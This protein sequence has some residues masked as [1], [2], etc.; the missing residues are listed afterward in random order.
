MLSLPNSLGS[1]PPSLAIL[2]EPISVARTDSSMVFISCQAHPTFMP[3]LGINLQIRP[4]VMF[5][6]NS[7]NQAL[8][9]QPLGD[10]FMAG[11]ENSICGVSVSTGR[12]CWVLQAQRL[13]L[14]SLY[15]VTSSLKFPKS[16]SSKLSRPQSQAK[17]PFG[18]SF[19]IVKKTQSL[20]SAELSTKEDFIYQIHELT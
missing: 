16:R 9:H 20:E 10:Q 1:V 17:I 14:C 15:S 13:V 4:L 18:D 11:P 3:S 19:A 2:P 7:I 6:G 5:W 8:V 12:T